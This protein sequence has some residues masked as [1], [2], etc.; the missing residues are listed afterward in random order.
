MEC[1]GLF[2]TLFVVSGSCQGLEITLDVDSIPFGAVVQNSSS[3]RQLIMNNTGDIGA[4]FTSA[5][6]DV[7]LQFIYPYFPKLNQEVYAYVSDVADSVVFGVVAQ[8]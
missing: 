7:I 8:I 4:R 3:T 1:A 6:F 5:S 2:Q